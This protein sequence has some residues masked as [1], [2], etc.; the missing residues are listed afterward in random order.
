M[1]FPRQGTGALRREQWRYRDLDWSVIFEGKFMMKI[2]LLILAAL[3]TAL[4]GSIQVDLLSPSQ[5][6]APGDVLQFLGTITNLSPT[7][8]VFFN[9]VSATSVSADLTIDI[10]PFLINAP[11]S[12]GPGEVSSLFDLF[13]ITIDPA[14]P[15]GPYFGNTVSLLGGADSNALDP[16]LDVNADVTVSTPVS[17]P[18]PSSIV[19]IMTALGLIAARLASTKFRLSS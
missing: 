3:G 1:A 9:S 5:T 4:A 6:G 19:L 13:D 12:L 16:L 18:E 11:L 14:T 8:T 10:I 7:D 2:L 15:D 17:T